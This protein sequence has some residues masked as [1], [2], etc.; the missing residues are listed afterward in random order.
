MY[1]T[2]PRAYRTALAPEVGAGH[3]DEV[4]FWVRVRRW[5]FGALMGFAWSGG[6]GRIGWDVVVFPE[7]VGDGVAGDGVADHGEELPVD[8]V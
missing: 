2:D 8:G 7:G 6:C 3:C 4:V 1:V 5:R